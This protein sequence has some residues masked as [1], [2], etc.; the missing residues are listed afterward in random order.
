[1]INAKP[2]ST[3]KHGRP[4]KVTQKKGRL[5]LCVIQFI[6]ISNNCITPWS[7]FKVPYHTS[8]SLLHS[9][10]R[11]NRKNWIKGIIIRQYFPATTTISL[12][13]FTTGNQT[14]ITSPYRIAGQRTPVHIRIDHQNCSLQNG[15][16]H[17]ITPWQTTLAS[18]E[19]KAETATASAPHAKLSTR[20]PSPLALHAL[21]SRH[22][23]PKRDPPREPSAPAPRWGGARSE[24]PRKP[25][26]LAFSSKR[27]EARSGVGSG[28]GN[29]NK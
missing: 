10:P 18:Q 7:W 5:C 11:A 13:F 29:G 24:R 25:K 28:A 14:L 17:R 15:S 22:P 21:D 16:P 26:G 6:N 12:L 4:E 9:D 19:T 8:P 1:M 3:W 20:R 23:T 27:E 2:F